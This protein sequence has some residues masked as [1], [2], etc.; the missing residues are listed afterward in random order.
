MMN[1]F[2]K[3]SLYGLLLLAVCG[4][5]ACSK[6]D[7]N[8]ES[9][10]RFTGPIELPLIRNGA[11]DIFVSHR[12]TFNGKETKTYSLEYDCS[13]KHARWVAFKFDSQT[14]QDNTGRNED[15]RPDPSIPAQYQRVQ[16]DFGAKGYDR[17]HI[18]ASEDRVYSV[19]ANQQTFYYSNMSPQ[20][21]SF[22]AG[23]WVELERAVQNWGRN[24]GF[25]DTL[26][27]AKGGTI[28]NENQILGYISNDRSKPIPKYYYM[29]VLCNKSNRYKAI[30]FW[31]E[32]KSYSKPYNLHEYAIS[33]DQLETLTGLNFFHNLP[34]NLENA[35]EANYDITGWPGL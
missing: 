12:T 8:A 19:E 24:S 13:K 23:I 34:D 16:S 31:F 33:I 26:Y 22:N 15:F 27:V 7:E 14:G 11:N 35:V 28:D 32:H 17:G 1:L 18:C 2:S 5:Q 25:R 29:A 9:E 10:N 20:R 30:G 3:K 6:S 4:L 21:N